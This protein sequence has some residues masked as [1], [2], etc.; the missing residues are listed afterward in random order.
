MEAVFV[1]GFAVFVVWAVRNLGKASVT[2]LNP[3]STQPQLDEAGRSNNSVLIALALIILFIA[4]TAGGA[5][6][7]GLSM[8]KL[9]NNGAWILTG[10]GEYRR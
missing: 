8:D 3:N 7:T 1:V 6:T 2:I 9:T 4:L 10:E 5:F